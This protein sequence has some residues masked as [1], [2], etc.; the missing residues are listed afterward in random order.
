MDNS[1]KLV[2]AIMAG[3][4]IGLSA[5][6]LFKQFV[7]F[8]EVEG[9]TTN[10]TKN[11]LESSEVSKESILTSQQEQQRRE[12]AQNEQQELEENLECARNMDTGECS[13]HDQRSGA[14][15]DMSSEQCS[16]HVDHQFSSY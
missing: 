5:Y 14:V 13:C 15:V 8:R 10:I 9:I 11:L 4:I 7:Y 12:Q 6:A 1:I 3:V 2:L 16:Q